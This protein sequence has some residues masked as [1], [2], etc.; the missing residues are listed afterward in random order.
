MSRY[1]GQA[2]TLR[3]IP[4]THV[5]TI[6]NWLHSPVIQVKSG[7]WAIYRDVPEDYVN[8]YAYAI[9]TGS[10]LVMSLFQDRCLHRESERA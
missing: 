3:S 5:R 7:E 2:T 6:S 4:Y 8:G 1:H 10:A 9:A